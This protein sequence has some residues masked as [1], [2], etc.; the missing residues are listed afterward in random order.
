MCQTDTLTDKMGIVHMPSENAT[1]INC[2]ASYISNVPSRVKVYAIRVD[3]D[4]PN[5]GDTKFSLIIF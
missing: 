1:D 5:E 3:L 4:G 2:T